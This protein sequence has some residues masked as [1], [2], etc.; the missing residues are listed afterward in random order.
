MNST[1]STDSFCNANL[2]IDH[3]YE[4]SVEYNVSSGT[5]RKLTL[6]GVMQDL[7][8]GPLGGG[9]ATP[10]S[11]FHDCG[12]RVQVKT[13]VD[14]ETLN[15][16]QINRL[17]ATPKSHSDSCAPL[18][19]C[20]AF[21]TE[22]NLC[23]NLFSTDGLNIESEPIEVF[24]WLPREAFEDLFSQVTA[25]Q[26]D[27]KMLSIMLRLVGKEMPSAEVSTGGIFGLKLSALDISENH[28]YAVQSFESSK[29][30]IPISPRPRLTKVHWDKDATITT[31]RVRFSEIRTQ[32][33]LSLEQPLEVICAGEV[34]GAHGKPYEGATVDCFFREHDSSFIRQSTETANFGTFCF[35]P[36]DPQEKKSL[37]S[38]SL[39]LLYDS[40]DPTD[41]VHRL[42]SLGFGSQADLVL[43]LDFNCECLDGAEKVSGG[44]W[45]Y[46]LH[47]TQVL[48]TINDNPILSSK[49]LTCIDSSVQKLI[50]LEIESRRLH[51]D[52]AAGQQVATKDDINQA[53]HSIKSVQ[54]KEGLRT[55]IRYA[56][57]AHKRLN[58]TVFYSIGALIVSLAVVLTVL[59]RT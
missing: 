7:D 42:L 38:L 36:A 53:I 24:L 27:K 43:T 51:S 35:R 39:H 41:M 22:K 13:P 59:W 6:I 34:I 55:L 9:P 37:P 44:V 46:E 23:G 47:T 2:L 4:P 12:V 3:F 32:Y 26:R 31:L 20:G 33:H 17:E 30:M 15:R 28:V 25:A 29:T 54:D 11:S 48:A 49:S 16:L 21:T 19:I 58:S 40:Q 56:E 10:G 14:F 1:T 18:L 8:Y 50:D 45:R 5:V 57:M 52:T